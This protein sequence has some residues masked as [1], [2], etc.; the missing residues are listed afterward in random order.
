MVLDHKSAKTRGTAYRDVDGSG[1]I[2]GFG[3]N[4]LSFM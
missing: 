1:V 4:V 2:A 3:R